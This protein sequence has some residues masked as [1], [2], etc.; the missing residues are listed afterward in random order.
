MALELTHLWKIARDAVEER[1]LAQTLT[2][3]PKYLATYLRRRNAWQKLEEADGFD[4]KYGTDTTIMLGPADFGVSSEQVRH[5]S[6]YRATLPRTFERIIEAMDIRHEDYIFIDFG[7]GK[8]R[9]LLLASELPFKKIIGVELSPKLHEVAQK[10]VE[11]YHSKTQ[12]GSNIELACTDATS[13][14]LP[15]ENTV[16]YFFD[17]FELPI[18]SAVVENMKR[19]LQKHPRKVFIAYVNPTYCVA[20]EQSGFLERIHSTRGGPPESGKEYPWSIYKNK[21]Q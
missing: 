1:G 19:S 18:M 14:P 12:K 13:Y 7:S 6:L 5:A 2:Q 3:G 9:T 11:I 17:P 16:F 8:G 4:K 10:N 15:V 20:M 21:M